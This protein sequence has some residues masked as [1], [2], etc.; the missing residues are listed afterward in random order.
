MD[1]ITFVLIDESVLTNGMRVLIAGIDT[2]QFEKNPVMF[3]YHKQESLPIG[4]WNNIRKEN[5]Q[6]LADPEFD[7]E[8][9]DEDVQRIIRKV[10]KGYI[11]MASAGL[12][13]LELSDDPIYKVQGQTDFTVIRSRI[14][15]ASIVPIGRNH[16]SLAFRMY[17]KDGAELIP[18]KPET[19]L[20]LADFIVSPKIEKKMSKKYL[21]ILNLAD[22]ATD[23]MVDAAIEKLANDKKAAEDRALELADKVSSY[24]NAE[25]EARKAEALNLCDAAVADGRLDAKGKE[26]ILNLFDKDFDAAKTTLES[27]AKPVVIRD[28]LNNADKSER[29]KLEGM[30]FGEIDKAGLQLLCKDSYPD[31]YK[32]KYKEF[33]GVDPQ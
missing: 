30:T 20:K 11:K 29:E 24:E 22:S 18:G 26:A 7:E 8:D 23:E 27:I 2:D 3:Y 9:N 4:K 6:L 10:K 5:G 21:E 16:N 17:D 32:S 13:D 14:R 31:L 19:A 12:V 1:A 33:Y 28:A 15:E 25:A